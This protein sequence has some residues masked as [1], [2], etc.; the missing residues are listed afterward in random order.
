MSEHE[1]RL[2]GFDFAPGVALADIAEGG[3]ILGHV[4]GD[5]VLLARTRSRAVRDR[6]RMHPLPRSARRGGPRRGH[7]PL[8]LASRLFQPAYRRGA[9]RGR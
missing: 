2:D 5:A 8:S 4:A 3:M 1:K 7:R 9:A 6:R